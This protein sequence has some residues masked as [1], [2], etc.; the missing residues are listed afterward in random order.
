MRRRARWVLLGA[1]GVVACLV[2]AHNILDSITE[3][4]RDESV[5]RLQEKLAALV[6]ELQPGGDEN[7]QQGTPAQKQQTGSASEDGTGDAQ[8]S[9]ARW[10]QLFDLMDERLDYENNPDWANVLEVLW[11]LRDEDKHLSDC[12]PEE[13]AQMEAFLKANRDL[14]REIYALVEQGVPALAVELSGEVDDKRHL[15]LDHWWD[16]TSCCRLLA[17]D[18]IVNSK[19]QNCPDAVKAVIAWMKL[20]DRLPFGYE[21]RVYPIQTVKEALYEV[22]VR[23]TLPPELTQALLAQ[24]EDSGSQRVFAERLGRE[25]SYQLQWVSDLP[26]S[27][28][29]D[30]GAAPFSTAQTYLL[31]CGTVAQ[32]WLNM[33]V[34]VFADT[35]G[36]VLEL[37]DLPYHKAEPQLARINE[38]LDNRPLGRYRAWWGARDM[39]QNKFLKRAY[40]EAQLDLARLAVVL[41]QH[42]ARHGQYPDTL[43]AVAPDLSGSLPLDPFTGEPYRYEPSVDRFQLYSAG[44]NRIDD[45]GRQG[46][47]DGDIAWRGRDEE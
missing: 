4:R 21:P 35:T 22:F 39:V 45:G 24:L 27:F 11:A 34:Q 25:A 15:M 36:Q 37:T 32:P 18:A 13:L 46:T 3:R 44:P 14:V 8:D 10:K 6:P 33:D 31:V 16:V 28:H 12:T 42:R 9:A 47:R 26:R 2:V 17:L 1:I 23:E 40:D 19:R 41:E 5:A 20:S 43:D 29:E 7:D 38:E 30:Y